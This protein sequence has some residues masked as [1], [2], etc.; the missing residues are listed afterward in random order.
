MDGR[1]K[2]GKAEFQGGTTSDR[3]TTTTDECIAPCL[4]PSRAVCSARCLS[5][6]AAPLQKWPPTPISGKFVPRNKG[7]RNAYFWPRLNFLS[8]TGCVLQQLQR[9]K[10]TFFAQ[11]FFLFRAKVESQF[12]FLLPFPHVLSVP[13]NVRKYNHRLFINMKTQRDLHFRPTLYHT[14]FCCIAHVYTR[15]RAFLL[16]LAQGCH[17]FSA[18][19]FSG[20]RKGMPK[21]NT[22]FSEKPISTRLF[23]N[24]PVRHWQNLPVLEKSSAL[25]HTWYIPVRIH[26]KKR[27]KK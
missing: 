16:S 27:S 5:L 13:L 1:R 6:Q 9:L 12:L 14:W 3:P 22:L 26:L 24:H 23:Q 21:S 19:V 17:R 2:K 25:L 10:K 20:Q 18:L 4:R 11:L 8:E 7:L 15:K